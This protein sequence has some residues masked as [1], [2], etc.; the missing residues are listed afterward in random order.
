MALMRFRATF[1]ITS[2][3]VVTAGMLT[4]ASAR[5][6]TIGEGIE[7]IW[8]SAGYGRI[9]TI[10]KDAATGGRRLTTFD[11]TKISCLN[12]GTKPQVRE[13]GGEVGFGDGGR[14]ELTVR[15]DGDHAYL[16]VLG[17]LTDIRLDRLERQPACPSPVPSDGPA[18]RRL[19]FDIFWK[20]FAENYPP[21]EHWPLDRSDEARDRAAL[22]RANTDKKLDELLRSMV[23]KLGDAHTGVTWKDDSTNGVRPGTRDS[24]DM[25]AK[26][27]R[28][29]IERRLGIRLTKVIGGVEYATGLPGGL[30]YLRVN[31]LDGF[32]GDRSS[33]DTDRERFNGALDTVFGRAR[34]DH[35]EGLILDMRLNDGGHDVLGLDLAARLTQERHYAFKKRGRDLD[36][37]SGFTPYQDFNVEPSTRPG[38]APGKPAV[39]LVSDMTVSAGETAI[40][41]MRNR[42][43][44]PTL[45]GRATQGIFSD[46]MFPGLPG[47]WTFELSNEDYRPKDGTSLEGVGI[48]ATP[49]F[50]TPVFE[51]DE[52]GGGC[53]SALAKAIELLAQRPTPPCPGK[54]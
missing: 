31:R 22:E 21:Y 7:G 2:I 33:Y 12:A 9:I 19:A 3:T 18:R 27:V 26:A 28:T 40:L 29:A 13:T 15:G 45:I 5:S 17:T 1:A 30:G 10:A 4:S 11:A 32:S 43:P 38:L 39:V 50:G 42:K 23:R 37:P 25:D 53:D 35:W 20:T 6:A 51:P 34:Q 47:G 46:Q 49:G 48:P 52:L 41:A 44:E 8:K 54:G 16:R 36:D 24:E 14:R